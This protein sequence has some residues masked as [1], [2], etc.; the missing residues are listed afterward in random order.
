MP[1]EVRLM[2]EVEPGWPPIIYNI[3]SGSVTTDEVVSCVNQSLALLDQQ[4]NLVDIVG[5]FEQETNMLNAKGVI[6]QK[7]LLDQLTWHEKLDQVIIVDLNGIIGG[8]FTKKTLQTF[9]S[10]PELKISIL[11]SMDELHEYLMKK[12][13]SPVGSP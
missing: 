3:Y 2:K 8:D 9:L 6:F 10:K 4:T 12:Y 7:P 11:S 13:Q 1:V 5:I